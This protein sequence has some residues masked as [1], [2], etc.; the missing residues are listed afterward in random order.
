MYTI[1]IAGGTSSNKTAVVRKVLKAL[2]YHRVLLIPLW[3]LLLVSCREK[4]KQVSSIFHTEQTVTQASAPD[5]EEL[6]KNGEIIAV[7]LSGPDTYFEFRGQSFGMQYEMIADFARSKGLR[8]RMEIAHDTLELIRLLQEGEA[9]VITLPMPPTHGC[10]LTAVQD[11]T[12]KKYSPSSDRKPLGWLSRKSS[13]GLAKALDAW[14]KPDIKDLIL[15]RQRKQSHKETRLQARQHPRPKVKDATHG[16]ISDFDALF[17]R[18]ASVCGWDWRLLAAQCYQ[19]S[20]FDPQAVSWA[21][22]QGLMQLMPATANQYGVST[23]VFNPE[24]NIQ[25]ATRFIAQ[26]NAD[27]AQITDPNERI[28]FI[29]AS[30]NGGPGHIR[31][32]MSLTDKYGGNPYLWSHVRTYILALSDPQYYRDPIVKYGYLRGK[33]TAHYVDAIRS[34]WMHYKGIT[35]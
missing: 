33:E 15:T 30:Y 17:R 25:A 7:T 12:G 32:A 9:D 13:E 11:S 8:I 6:E 34:H 28:N 29:L 22:A 1:G 14:Y 24:Q 26:L 3:L 2:P 23:D 19:E 21:G 10:T 5:I 35:R 4:D 31:D 18:H 20:C 16:I 27:F